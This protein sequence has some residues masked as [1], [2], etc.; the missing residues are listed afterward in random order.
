MGGNLGFLVAKEL[1]PAKHVDRNV[2]GR[3]GEPGGRILWNPIV[4]PGLH[5]TCEGFLDHV[6]RQLQAVDAK[7]S[8]QNRDK[9]AGFM[10]EEVLRQPGNVSRWRS[11]LILNLVLA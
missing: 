11:L 8:G 1:L 6:L 3:L 10:T 4:G 7:N 2:L 9:L 5:R